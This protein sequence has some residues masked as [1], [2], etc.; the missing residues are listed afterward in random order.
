MPTTSAKVP[1]ARFLH[2]RGAL[3]H[4]AKQDYGGNE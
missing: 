1:S 4:S 3:A 2:N